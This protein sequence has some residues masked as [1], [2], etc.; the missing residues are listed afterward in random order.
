M[1]LDHTVTTDKPYADAVDAVTAAVEANGFRVQA[2]H[3]VAATLAEKGFMREPLT[4]VEMC[5]AKHAHA[6]LAQDVLIGLMLPCPI[7][8]WEESGQVSIATM[9]PT[10]IAEFFPE[11]DIAQT[12]QAVEDAILKIMNEAAE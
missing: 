6:V 3:D 12:A 7:M 2:V 8:V 5:N 4:I 9:K 10:L 11:A 1:R